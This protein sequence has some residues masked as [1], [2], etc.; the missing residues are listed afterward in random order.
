MRFLGVLAVAVLCTTVMNAPAAAAAKIKI[1]YT[2]VYDRIRPEPQ[3]NVRM[4]AN[5]DVALE[6]GGKVNEGVTRT[7]GSVSDRFKTGAKLGGGQW[8]VISEKQLRR[9]FD[10]PQSTL[11]LTI[12]TIDDK[13]CKLD[14]SW[15]LKP[16]FNEYKFR[17]ITDGTMAF[18]TEPKVKSTSCSIQ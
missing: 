13:S 2:A 11:V 1:S 18:F 12:T 15:T 10:Q 9:T 6:E 5:M 16:G 17:R 4:T 8:E 3:K 14:L 7:A